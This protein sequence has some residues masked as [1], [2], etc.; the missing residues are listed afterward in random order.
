MLLFEGRCAR[1]YLVQQQAFTKEKKTKAGA[2][3]NYCNCSYIHL[4]EAALLHV[5]QS[6]TGNIRPY[7][8]HK[9]MVRVRPEED[10]RIA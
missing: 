8:S 2:A 7:H 10:V 4:S 9:K 3:F 1:L 5:I 6:L